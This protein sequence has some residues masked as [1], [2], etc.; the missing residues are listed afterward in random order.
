MEK[1]RVHIHHP[2]SKD[3]FDFLVHYVQTR[4]E[5]VRTK[6]LA[7]TNTIFFEEAAE[8]ISRKFGIMRT[9]AACRNK[10]RRFFSITDDAGLDDSDNEKCGP[11]SDESDLDAGNTI[12]VEPW[13]D[14]EKNI[15]YTTIKEQREME[16]K[17]GIE[18]LPLQATIRLAHNCLR[19][20][21]FNRTFNSVASWWKRSG[22]TH[23]NYDERT[24]NKESNSPTLSI[25]N[26]EG[27]VLKG[28]KFTRSLRPVGLTKHFQVNRT[29]LTT[30][31][32]AEANHIL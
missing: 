25:E 5:E 22:R 18:P 8:E 6:G 7:L 26:A 3:E 2:W 13:S 19:E 31:K 12:H 4:Q 14:Q 24:H 21:G 10:W 30:V 16:V 29:R 9:K 32:S 27:S 15:V 20:R 28:R 23:F 11:D 17:K 1:S